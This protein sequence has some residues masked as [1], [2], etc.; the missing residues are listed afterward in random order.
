V[1]LVL[2]KQDALWAD[3]RRGRD[4]WQMPHRRECLDAISTRFERSSDARL[5]GVNL[6]ASRC[7][8]TPGGERRS[9]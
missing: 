1:V 4:D 8:S 9:K 5:S 6:G 2:L 3:V 7:G